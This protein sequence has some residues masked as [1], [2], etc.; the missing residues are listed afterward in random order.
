MDKAGITVATD[1]RPVRLSARKF[2]VSLAGSLAVAPAFFAC[3]WLYHQST[4]FVYG[5]MAHEENARLILL[6]RWAV[7]TAL[8]LV[9]L[10]AIGWFKIWRPEHKNKPFSLL[11]LM[12]VLAFIAF[13]NW[14][15]GILIFALLLC[16]LVFSQL[17]AVVVRDELRTPSVGWGRGADATSFVRFAV[18]FAAVGIG[19]WLTI[20]ARSWAYRTRQFE[21]IQRKG[22][23]SEP[24]SLQQLAA[25]DHKEYVLLSGKE[26]RVAYVAERKFGSG[27]DSYS[28]KYGALV[29]RNLDKQA[30]LAWKLWVYMP[31]DYKPDEFP[32]IFQTAR[33]TVG[34][35]CSANFVTMHDAAI[36]LHFFDSAYRDEKTSRIAV[37][38]Q[39][40]IE[41]TPEPDLV[42]NENI[43]RAKLALRSKL[44]LLLQ[45]LYTLV[46]L[47]ELLFIRGK[48]KASYSDAQPGA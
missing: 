46:H 41:M 5:P 34:Q 42:Q 37:N 21:E 30:I 23:Y 24:A 6:V 14:V 16:A 7:F 47:I 11:I 27:D 44:L 43:W 8:T 29:D 18:L 33:C 22:L 31:Y 12:P 36:R 20:T 45:V 3:A 39:T 40:L 48:L 28:L 1:V 19:I 38:G 2:V 17:F 15:F 4:D 26:L 35:N 9:L 13:S 32:M 25:G 10:S